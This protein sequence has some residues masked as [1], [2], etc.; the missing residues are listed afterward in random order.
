MIMGNKKALVTLFYGP[1][2]QIFYIPITAKQVSLA[3][4]GGYIPSK[5]FIREYQNHYF[6]PKRS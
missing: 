1:Q 6:K 4:R 5:I 3:I 2:T